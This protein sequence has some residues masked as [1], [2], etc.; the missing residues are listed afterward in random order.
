MHIKD[1]Q[2]KV[3]YRLEQDL[4]ANPQRV[5]KTQALTQDTSRP[6]MGLNGEH[7]LFASKE[8]WQS[9]DERRIEVRIYTGTIQ[10]LYLAGQDSDEDATNDFEYLCND[11]KTRSATCVVNDDRDLGLYRVGATVFMTYALDILKK[12]PAKDGGTNYAE[13]LLEVMVA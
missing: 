10:R 3:V 13:I 7:G 5:A 8:W 2:G 6:N 1:L 9:I 12:Q 11:G 4:A